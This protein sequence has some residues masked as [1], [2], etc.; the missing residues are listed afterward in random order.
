MKRIKKYIT[1]ALA[2]AMLLTFSGCSLVERTEE[3]IGKT[4]L[5][6][7]GKVKITRAD[8]DQV[9]YYQ[10]EQY[11]EQYGDDFENDETIKDTIKQTR[12]SALNSLI[13]EQ[14]LFA[15][16][17]EIGAEFTDD[18]VETEVESRV[19]M[20]KDY[21]GDDEAYAEFLEQYG[22]TEDEF[23]DYW[24]KQIKLEFIAEKLLEDVTVTDDEAKDYYNENVDSY[25]LEAGA[26]VT[27]ILFS[28]ADKGEAQAKEARELAVN[29]KT[30]EE[31]SEMDAYKGDNCITED[32]G[33][34]VS[35][36]NST[37]V[38]EFVTGFK[39]LK[40]GEI[41]QPVKTSYGWHLI[42]VTGVNTAKKTQ[43]YDEVA[44]TVKSTVLNNKKSAEYETKIEDFKST[45]SV[46]IYEDRI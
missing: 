28:D 5:A 41:S 32:L 13:E 20:Y 18:E 10:L 26:N 24:R 22:Y 17:E 40:E 21:T 29:G 46:K 19:K 45:M 7:V 43:T 27:H 34:Q 39:D 23:E 30:F 35:E 33:Y 9:M 4:V 42:K 25:A 1:M 12:T 31:I 16:Q 37:L 11:K 14:I 38:S 6:K 44:E 36:N 8:V 2:G 15:N 3:S